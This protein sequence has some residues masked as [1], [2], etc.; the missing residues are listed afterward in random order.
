MRVLGNILWFCFGGAFVALVH[1]ALG[2]ICCLTIIFF[3]FG[4]QFF[5]LA[6]LVAFPFGK[7][8]DTDCSLHP[9]LNIAWMVV[10][11]YTILTFLIGVVLCA[12]IILIP[13]G[14]QCFKIARLSA[15]PFGA[16]IE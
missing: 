16:I 5:K 4:L 14:K 11:V 15:M 1:F 12:T 3:P 10:D 8:V 2:L 6:R 7:I 13:F 9:Y